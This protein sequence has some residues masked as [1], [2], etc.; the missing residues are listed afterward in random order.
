[1]YE[2]AKD[3]ARRRRDERH[4]RREEAMEEEEE[5][6]FYEETSDRQKDR[7]QIHWNAID[8]SVENGNGYLKNGAGQT[9]QVPDKPLKREEKKE[10]LMKDSFMSQTRLEKPQEQLNREN[11]HEII[12]RNNAQKNID[13]CHS[14]ITVYEDDLFSKLGVGDCSIDRNIGFSNATLSTCYRNDPGLVIATRSIEVIFI[15]QST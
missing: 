13:I 11:M 3:S 8:Q 15:H 2:S 7:R 14:K 6:E 12:L 5:E 10:A 1:M 4:A 9:A